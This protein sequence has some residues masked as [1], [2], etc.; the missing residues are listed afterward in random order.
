ML[1]DLVTLVDAL[2]GESLTP[3]WAREAVVDDNVLG[4]KI[5]R[6][7]QKSFQFLQRLYGLDEHRAPGVATLLR[8]S[9]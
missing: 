6:T 1:K 2:P 7:R 9:G 4:K 5:H 8:S 3:G